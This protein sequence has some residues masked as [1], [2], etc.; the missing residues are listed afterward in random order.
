MA[1]RVQIDITASDKTKQP[2]ESAKRAVRGVKDEAEAV[3]TRG[4]QGVSRLTKSLTGAGAAASK[5]Q[6]VLSKVFIPAAVAGAVAGLANRWRE[7]RAEVQQTRDELD[8]AAED[9]QK[10]TQQLA[11]TARDV[12]DF[13]QKLLELMQAAQA[14][15]AKVNALVE[16]E[17]GKRGNLLAQATRL[18]FTRTTVSE[19]ERDAADANERITAQLRQ[20][21]ALLERQT[22]ADRKRAEAEKDRQRNTATDS[23]LARARLDAL[24]DEERE[25]VEFTTRRDELNARLREADTQEERAKIRELIDIEL[26]ETLRALDAIK[27]RKDRD[28][29]EE[30]RKNRE[31]EDKRHREA[32][33]NIERERQA[34][35]RAAQ[36]LLN[37]Q[38]QQ[39]FGTSNTSVSAGRSFPVKVG[40]DFTRPHA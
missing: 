11:L 19:L 36:E 40:G 1:D 25:W 20:Q 10:K 26:G 38:E 31:A 23:E 28:R 39:R 30:E 7:V 22:E 5:V 29:D 18:A 27:A 2:A 12:P 17:R 24:S 9:F 32:M 35:V 15:Q 33:E 34:K 13:Q 37:L 3:G 6:E 14:E 8:R 21:V 4:E 16:E